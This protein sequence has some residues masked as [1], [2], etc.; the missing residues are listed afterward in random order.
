MQPGTRRSPACPLAHVILGEELEELPLL[1]RLEAVLLQRVRVEGSLLHVLLDARCHQLGEELLGRH[2]RLRAV[3]SAV[4]HVGLQ[5]K[6][7]QLGDD[8]LRHHLLDE[9]ELLAGGQHAHLLGSPAL[10]VGPRAALAGERGHAVGTPHQPAGQ[11]GQQPHGER[12]RALRG[13]TEGRA[14]GGAA[15]GPVRRLPHPNT[16]RSHW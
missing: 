3:R 12:P 1:R 14:G 7:R 9:D 11:L 10:V 5:L 16:A 6:A 4:R 15:A 8:E 13:R 2:G